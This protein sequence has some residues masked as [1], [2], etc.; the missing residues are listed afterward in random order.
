MDTGALTHNLRE[1]RR[2]VAPPVRLMAV[3]K[4]EAYGH[5]L[6]CASRAFLAGGA[7]MLGVHSWAEARR[8]REDGIR[9]PILILGPVSTPEAV[10]A[11]DAG[12][13]ITVSSPAG[14]VWAA[15]AGREL[16]VHLKVETGVNRQGLTE[17]E[18]PVVREMLRQNPQLHPVGLSSHFADVEDT[19]DH[20]FA[21]QQMD[22]FHAQRDA[23]ADVLKPDPLI[24]MTCSAATLLWPRIH[25]SMVR[26]GVA[27]YGI[28][29]SRETLVSFRESGRGPVDLR[30]AMTL[31][32]RIS[33]VRQVPAGQTVGYGRG[34]KAMTD[35]TIAVLAV[36]YSDGLPRALGGRAH[37]LVGGYRAPLV[38]RICMNL[39]M[40]DVS[41]IPGV[42]AGDPAV[43][44]G[45][46]G[47]EVIT[48]EMLAGHLGTIPYEVLTLPGPTWRR[49]PKTE[50]E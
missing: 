5:G 1:M 14:L 31:K 37:V 40:A 16:R 15:A 27:A 41:N 50:P 36:G 3:V 9:Q 38:G 10:A 34:W 26:V 46:Q 21:R 12:V 44:L 13:D 48:A 17:A 11:A 20:G 6:L 18:L 47:D 28:W 45:R 2:L 24:H 30:P 23:L 4:A 32:V 35:S 39:C 49:V 43:L 7:D 25:G 42:R 22:R 33:Q 29:P 8:L 19:T